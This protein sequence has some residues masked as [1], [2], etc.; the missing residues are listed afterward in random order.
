MRLAA[1]VRE[2]RGE[3]RVDV[4][5]VETARR[6]RDVD[7]QSGRAVDLGDDLRRR[8]DHPEIAGDWRLESQQLVAPLLEDGCGQLDLLVDADQIVGRGEVTEKQYV[9]AL[10]DH[11]GDLLRERQHLGSNPSS[12]W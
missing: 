12:S 1:H 2:N 5:A 10:R 7:H 3:P 6:L 11:P 8:H 4:H 9:G